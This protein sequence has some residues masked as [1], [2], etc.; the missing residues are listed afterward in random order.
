MKSSY[1]FNSTLNGTYRY[2]IDVT[3]VYMKVFVIA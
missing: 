2:C 1:M 3:Y